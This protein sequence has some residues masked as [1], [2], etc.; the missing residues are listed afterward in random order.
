MSQQPPPPGDYETP[1][2]PPAGGPPHY[3]APES[4]P[5]DESGKG[6]FG[7]LF[8]FCFTSFVTPKFVKVVYVLATVGFALF[9][10]IVVVRAFTA[11]PIAGLLTLII[12]AVAFIIYLAVVRM[13]LEFYYALVRMSEDIHYRLPGAR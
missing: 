2:Q 11:S 10:V 8:D 12:G 3:P 7:S 1:S 9:Y 5:L 6:F 4:R 13:T